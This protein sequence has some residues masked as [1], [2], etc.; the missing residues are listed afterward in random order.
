MSPGRKQTLSIPQTC[1]WKMKQNFPCCCCREIKK[2]FTHMENFVPISIPCFRALDE[3]TPP[4]K[5]KQNKTKTSLCSLCTKLSISSSKPAP[6]D[7]GDTLHNDLF[8][9]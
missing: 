5:T 3:T 6:Q 4:V 2:K 9:T 8:Y 7:D 1:M